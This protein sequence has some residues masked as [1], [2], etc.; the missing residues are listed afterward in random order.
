MGRFLINTIIM[1]AVLD[2]IALLVLTPNDAE[3]TV[4][5]LGL[6]VLGAFSMLTV[7]EIRREA[8]SATSELKKEPEEGH[9]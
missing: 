6:I 8:A 5:V 4:A 3:F 9:S 2:L 7:Y 1:L